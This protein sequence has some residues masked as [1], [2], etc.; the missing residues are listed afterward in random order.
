ML[1]IKEKYYGSD[2]TYWIRFILP[3][4]AKK[5]KVLDM[6]AG[7]GSITRLLNEKYKIETTAIGTKKPLIP[8]PGVNLIVYD[9][10]KIPFADNSF[11]HCVLRAILHHCQNPEKVLLEAKR[12]TKENIFVFE[13]IYEGNWEKSSTYIADSIVN[14]GNGLLDNTIFHPRNNK[15]F[16]QWLKTFRKLGF[17]VEHSEKWRTPTGKPI[18]FRWHFAFFVLSK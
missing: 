7:R 16:D 2:A 6:G 11:D 5:D 13:D 12:V 18:P 15:T 10:K 1:N 9:G 14:L 4:V 17:K 8:V 3:F